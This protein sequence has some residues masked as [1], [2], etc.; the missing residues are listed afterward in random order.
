MLQLC[1]GFNSSLFARSLHHISCRQ[2]YDKSTKYQLPFALTACNALLLKASYVHGLNVNLK[3]VNY[4]PDSSL[5]SITS[6]VAG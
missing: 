5:N 3:L 6:N 2:P 1:D 4:V